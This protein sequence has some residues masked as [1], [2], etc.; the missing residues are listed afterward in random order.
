MIMKNFN[1]RNLKIMRRF[2]RRCRSK[3]REKLLNKVVCV[4]AELNEFE[5]K[6]ESIFRKHYILDIEEQ[7]KDS[8]YPNQ[9]DDAE[10]IYS[11]LN[12]QHKLLVNLIKLPQE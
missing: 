6:N 3:A 8:I 9:I 4:P 11:S 12:N 10:L 7:L 5:K 1:T 2:L